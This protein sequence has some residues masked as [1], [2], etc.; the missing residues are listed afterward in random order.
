[1]RKCNFLL[2]MI[3]SAK[4]T[5]PCHA[6]GRRALAP[7]TRRAADVKV[8]RSA[9]AI[10]R[11]KHLSAVPIAVDVGANPGAEG[12]P[13]AASRLFAGQRQDGIVLVD[14][15]TGLRDR[16]RRW[17]IEFRG[18][19]PFNGITLRSRVQARPLAKGSVQP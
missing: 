2:D 12:C 13:G 1:M 18:R 3:G 17:A 9:A 10:R 6:Q 4:I 15:R 8:Q 19:T 11:S 16:D 14:A 5:M 7:T